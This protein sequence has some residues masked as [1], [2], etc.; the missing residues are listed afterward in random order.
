[1][2]WKITKIGLLR[3]VSESNWSLDGKLSG[4]LIG[5]F[6]IESGPQ[7]EGVANYHTVIQYHYTS[8]PKRGGVPKDPTKIV[9]LC[10]IVRGNLKMG[11]GTCIV[12]CD[13]SV[14]RTGVVIALLQMMD[15]VD[16]RVPEIDIFATVLKLR[17]DRMLMVT[18]MVTR[19]STYLMLIP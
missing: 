18:C 11:D 19:R 6:S 4:F 12:H 9:E 8:W 17:A 3:H 13:D 5:L 1:M 10:R 15:V 7:I 2:Y 16:S 14:G